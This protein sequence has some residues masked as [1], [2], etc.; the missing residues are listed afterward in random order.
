MNSLAFLLLCALVLFGCYWCGYQHGKTAGELK[1]RSR[2][3]NWWSEAEAGVDEVRQ[4]IWRE[5]G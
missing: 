5:E 1:W 2:E 3:Q 4:K